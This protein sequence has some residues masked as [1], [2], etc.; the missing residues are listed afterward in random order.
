MCRR[1]PR[2][3]RAVDLERAQVA[4]VDADDGGPGVDGAAGL[5]LVV[6]LD[7]SGHAE[8]LGV[9]PQCDEVTLV[10]RR[11]DQQDEVGAVGAGLPHLV[12]A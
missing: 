12:A 2:E 4:G 5:V 6:H 7:E 8:R 3:R 10:E 9:L 1:E 11:D